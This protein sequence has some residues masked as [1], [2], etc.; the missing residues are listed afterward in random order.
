MPAG[1]VF[2]I[3]EQP[4]QPPFRSDG[5]YVLN[6]R[7]LYFFEHTT[8]FHSVPTRCLPLFTITVSCNFKPC[9]P[10]A[11]RLTHLN[12]TSLLFVYLRTRN[13][14]H[15]AHHITSRLSLCLLC[16]RP[17]FSHISYLA[18]GACD[19]ASCSHHC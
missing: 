18:R 10:S 2:C 6:N 15:P 14:N 16:T 19:A 12:V 1:N 17:I 9:D 5:C 13:V 3:L 8:A 11:L 7:I 4:F